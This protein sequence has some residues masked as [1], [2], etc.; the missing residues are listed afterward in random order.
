LNRFIRLSVAGLVLVSAQ[1]AAQGNAR[2]DTTPTAR[3]G[4]KRVIPAYRNRI[5]GVFD[6]QT[7]LPVEGAEVSDVMIGTKSLTSSTGNVSLFFL[8]EGASLVRIRK[9]GYEAQTFMVS[10]APQDSSTITVV[11]SHVTELPAVVSTDSAPHYISARLREFEERRKLGFGYFIPEAELR[12]READPLA[13]V[14]QA[15][16]PGINMMH[17]GGRGAYLVSQRSPG[18]QPAVFLDAVPLAKQQ[19][20]P[21]R[22]VAVDLSQFDVSML[23]AVEFYQGGATLPPEFNVTASGCGALLLWTRER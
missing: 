5:I 13:D 10:I 15:K 4:A 23:G 19:I 12:K 3:P 8:P 6:G 11:L 14:I 1:L 7:Y 17:V 9:V 21:S 22:K 16:V 2:P 20:P 18:C